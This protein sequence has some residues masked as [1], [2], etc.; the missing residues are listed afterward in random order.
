MSDVLHAFLSYDQKAEKEVFIKRFGVNFRIKGLTQEEYY[1]LKEQA[2]HKVGKG[3]SQ[4][5]ELELDGLLI[6][7]GVVEPNFNDPQVISK[8]KAKDGADAALKSLLFGELKTVQAEILK[9][10]G[11]EDD[12]DVEEAKN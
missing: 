8:F 3:K 9:L 1:E 5:N 4:V 12:E 11:F 10:S 7:K 2:T 6:A